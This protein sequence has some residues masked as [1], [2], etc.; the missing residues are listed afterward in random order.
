MATAAANLEVGHRNVNLPYCLSPSLR[1]SPESSFFALCFFPA[2]ISAGLQI[3][4]HPSFCPIFTF[5]L[6]RLFIL[7]IDNLFGTRVLPMSVEPRLEKVRKFTLQA[8]PA[9]IMLPPIHN[10]PR[11]R[12]IP[13]FQRPPAC[14]ESVQQAYAWRCL[15]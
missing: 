14:S 3:F 8:R 15:R 10:S 6:L 13:C 7:R 1:V 9:G 12:I 5:L 4:A 2:W 11:F